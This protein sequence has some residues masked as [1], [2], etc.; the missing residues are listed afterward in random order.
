LRKI[1]HTPA[2]DNID[3]IIGA[4][5]RA[6]IAVVTLFSAVLILMTMVGVIYGMTTEND[7]IVT[8]HL[9]AL[10]IVIAVTLVSFVRISH[11]SV[12][13]SI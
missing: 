8:I 10:P 4:G 7:S 1:D 5:R 6:K 2:F 13:P 12:A 11:R 3:S 9:F